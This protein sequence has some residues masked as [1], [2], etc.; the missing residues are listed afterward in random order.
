MFKKFELIQNMGVFDDFNWERDFGKADKDNFKKINIIYGQNYSGK[1]TISR[2]FRS[3]ETKKIPTK[4]KNPKFRL[5]TDTQ[6]IISEADIENSSLDIRVFNEE[7]IKDN[8]QFLNDPNG[9]IKSFAILGDNNIRIE[10]EIR[11]LETELGIGLN[12]NT[13]GLFLKKEQSKE[14]SS[15]ARDLFNNMNMSL[16][17]K[18]SNKATG[19]QIGIKYNFE[20]FGE[21]NYNIVNIKK[22]IKHIINPDYTK[23]QDQEK[24]EHEQIIK[25]NK[26]EIV[27]EK[28]APKISFSYY[29]NT[30][31]ELCLY[32]LKTSSKISKLLHDTA[33]NNWVKQGIS[34]HQNIVECS[35]CGSKIS[36]ERWQIIY[37]HFDEE[38]KKLEEKITS[39][40]GNIEDEIKL[41]E[42]SF[43]IDKNKYYENF[44]DKID[45]LTKKYKEV[46]HAYIAQLKNIATHLIK[47]KDKPTEKFS[48]SFTE[49]YSEEVHNIFF[50]YNELV[51]VCNE[52]GTKLAKNIKNSQQALR[53]QEVADYCEVIN[54][55]E[56]QT[57][58]KAAEAD[59]KKLQA[60]ADEISSVADEKQTELTKNKLLL[61]NEGAGAKKINEYLNNYLGHKFLCLEPENL[62]YSVRFN[63]IRNGEI[64]FNLSEGEKSLIAFCYFMAKLNDINTANKKPIIWID[65]PISS[66][67][68]NHIFY[69]YSL[70]KAKIVDMNKYEQLFISTHNL[71]FFKYLQRLANP[72]DNKLQY[73][74]IQRLDKTSKI[75]LMPKYMKSSASEFI[76]L[77]GEIYKCSKIDFID[78]TNCQSFYNFGNNARKFLEILLYYLYPGDKAADR[79]QRFFEYDKISALLTDRINNEY[80]HLCGVFERGEMP[81]DVPE[82]KKVAKLII[83]TMKRKNFDQYNSFLSI[84][85]EDS[86][87]AATKTSK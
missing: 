73:Y 4:F 3:F 87:H 78:D 12:E 23:L 57:K 13:T 46:S 84:I 31:K 60:K 27:L 62:E 83:D 15:A 50:E 71:N 29:Y 63:I 51:K 80:S 53:L 8:L 28:P 35:F 40:V 55:N 54:Y 11:R 24:K 36:D 22:D 25:Q 64:A 75:N 77:F 32:E 5:L 67:D 2:I 58:I 48:F 81:V 10:A 37:N 33:L 34:L 20:K 59:Y 82:M 65:D 79:L 18:L 39:L 66:L 14:A 49:N 47:K 76:F 21:Q 70:I 69:I 19:E 68:S 7:F 52:F 86:Q 72:K 26:K 1:T 38:S 61:K 16:E 85:Y 74:T 43:G 45:C 9:E 42:N 41:I 56:E 17:K 30:A 6:E 44:H